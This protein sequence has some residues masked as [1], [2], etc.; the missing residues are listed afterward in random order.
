MALPYAIEFDHFCFN[1]G[2]RRILTDVHL[3]I[4]A[5]SCVGVIGPNGSG[6]TSLLRS[7]TGLNQPTAGHVRVFGHPPTRAWRRQHQIGYVPQ[8]KSIDREFPISVYEVVMLGR[9]AR[10]GFGHSPRAAD[11]AKVQQALERVNLT[12]VADRPIGQLSGGQLQ[13]VFIARALAQESAVLLLDEPEAGLDIPA[14]QNIYTLLEQL[15]DHRVTTVTTT[16]DLLALEFHHFDRIICLN[17][18]V[19]AY[20]PPEQ[21]LTPELLSRTF[22]GFPWPSQILYDRQHRHTGEGG[23]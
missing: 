7:I 21:V 10:L 5:G 16:H 6:K 2:S 8:L 15:H 11:H 19:I 9:T 1:Y 3:G 4:P 18:Q 23:T 14:Q 13:R 12:A 20:G 17:Q 22:G